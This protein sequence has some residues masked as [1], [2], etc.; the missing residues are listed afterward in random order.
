[1]AGTKKTRRQA[2]TATTLPTLAIDALGGCRGGGVD[3]RMS[4]DDMVR[5]M[6]RQKPVRGSRDFKAPE[7]GPLAALKGSGSVSG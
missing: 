7:L 4:M 5:A 3:R 6:P 1:M 2:A